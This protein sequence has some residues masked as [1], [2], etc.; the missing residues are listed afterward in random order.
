FAMFFKFA[1]R[2][3][4][5]FQEIWVA[6][7]VVT[8]GLGLLQRLFLLYTHSITN[9]NA[10]YGT[11]GSVVALLMWIY[12]TGSLIIFGGCLAAAQYEIRLSLSDQ[13]E[14]NRDDKL[15]S[16]RACATAVPDLFYASRSTAK[17]ASDF[18]LVLL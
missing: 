17:I 6:A 13:S 7:I 16:S 8:L 11:F 9:F 14:S 18:T 5:T 1:P 4:T 2:R 12:L 15:P 10:L 3:R